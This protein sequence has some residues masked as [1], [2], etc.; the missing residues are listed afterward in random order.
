MFDSLYIGKVIHDSDL[1][2]K[3]DTVP[4]NRVKVFIH[5][6]TPSIEED[7]DQPRGKTNE[8]TISTQALNAA[9][10]EF[11]AHVMMS[12]M[13]GGTGAKYNANTDIL[14]VSD[15]GNITDLNACP[16][17][18]AFS[19]THDGYLG[20]NS[21]GTA[22]VNVTANAY[23][24]DNRSNAYKG[25]MALPS[26][27][28][29]VVVSFINNERSMPIVLGVIPSVADVESVNG[30]GFNEEVYPNYPMAY[31]NLNNEA[32]NT[33]PT[34]PGNEST[35]TPTASADDTEAF[36][37][38]FGTVNG[39]VVGTADGTSEA[40]GTTTTASDGTV[41]TTNPDGTTTIT[42]PDKTV[43]TTTNDG[44]VTTRK[45][46]PDGTVTTSKST[47][48][49]TNTTT[50][51]YGERTVS[52]AHEPPPP[53]YVKRGNA[54][55]RVSGGL[56]QED[57]EYAADKKLRESL[58]NQVRATRLW[59][60]NKKSVENGTVDAKIRRSVERHDKNAGI[61]RNE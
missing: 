49:T 38:L 6:L 58:D 43:T 51:K 17:A 50:T 31:S 33:D 60:R 4:Q 14:S 10:Q 12:I 44:T 36:D 5:G 18:D 59:N 52:K 46:L 34:T 32:M 28:A 41:T 3:G 35:A 55:V 7:F 22:G 45:T 29:T 20:G 16:P 54:T 37:K 25:M 2:C 8:N 24:P 56:T 26:V 57:A 1:L 23:S 9:G 61:T 27:G 15:T 40:I 53:Q 13:G 42:K 21:I 39:E 11:Y 19:H 47:G 48:S 30:V